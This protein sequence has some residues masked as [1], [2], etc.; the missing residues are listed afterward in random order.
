[1]TPSD[2]HK[3]TAQGIASSADCAIAAMAWK[4]EPPFSP[5]GWK[6][7]IAINNLKFPTRRRKNARI[8]NSGA[9]GSFRD[10]PKKDSEQL[11]LELHFSKKKPWAERAERR[12][13]ARSNEKCGN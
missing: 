4:G 3:Q 1:M 13:V 11:S 8:R 5:S 12:L 9:D 2:P 7:A 6:L 10:V